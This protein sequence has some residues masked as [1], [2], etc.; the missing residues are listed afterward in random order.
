MPPLLEVA[1]E[2][3]SEY[4]VAGVAV[5]FGDVPRSPA[6]DDQLRSRTHV[7]CEPVKEPV[8][9][10]NPVKD[11]IGED[12]VHIGVE[13][14]PGQIAA[15]Q[16]GAVAQHLASLGDHRLRRVDPDH[17][18]CGD[19]LQQPRGDPAAA[20]AGVEQG[21]IAAELEALHDLLGPARLDLGDPVVGTRVPVGDPASR[22]HRPALL[23]GRE[24]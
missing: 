15:D 9:V 10:V 23:T 12:R 19:Q 22:C 17:P 4:D 3:R 24:T 6:L 16:R 11:G 7:R 20:A 14:E 1:Q 21:F 8:V 13:I 2:A 18:A 5:E